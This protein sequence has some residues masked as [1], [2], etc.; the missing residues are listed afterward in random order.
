MHQTARAGREGQNTK[1][2][3]VT[4]LLQLVYKDTVPRQLV[5]YSWYYCL[6]YQG[7]E[8]NPLARDG[9]SGHITNGIYLIPLLQLAHQAS[10]PMQSVTYPCYSW[11]NRPHYKLAQT[12]TPARWLGGLL[13][14][15]L[16]TGTRDCGFKPG[17]SRWIISG[18]W[19]ILS[20]PSFGEEVK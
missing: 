17:R 12:Y 2:S 5:C 9:T 7:I 13:V 8:Y 3:S 10:L 14:S 15:I 6:K 20:M 16:A 1:D 11:Q 18:I 19:K 4:S